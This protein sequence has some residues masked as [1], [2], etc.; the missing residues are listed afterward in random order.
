MDKI[1][2]H[3]RGKENLWLH[4]DILNKDMTAKAWFSESDIFGNMDIDKGTLCVICLLTP[5]RVCSRSS[6]GAA[7]C[8]RSFYVPIGPS[9]VPRQSSATSPLLCTPFFPCLGWEICL[10]FHSHFALSLPCLWS[11]LC[12]STD[13]VSFFP[14]F[15]PLFNELLNEK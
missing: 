6:W 7:D 12:Y 10:H 2:G 14:P 11:Y 4:I 5:P 8:A 1:S 9:D 13:E 3:C 15:W